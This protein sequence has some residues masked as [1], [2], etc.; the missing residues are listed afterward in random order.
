MA[1]R[2]EGM[3]GIVVSIDETCTVDILDG[4]DETAEV[5]STIDK[6]TELIEGICN[7]ASL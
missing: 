2:D 6:D 4:D 5:F 7:V 1:S 3:L